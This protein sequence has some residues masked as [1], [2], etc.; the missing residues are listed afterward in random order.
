LITG[1]KPCKTAFCDYESPPLCR[2]PAR[3]PRQIDCGEIP[4]ELG[5]SRRAFGALE[6]EIPSPRGYGVANKTAPWKCGT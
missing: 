1:E 6:R 2:N 3:D 4:E 5:A